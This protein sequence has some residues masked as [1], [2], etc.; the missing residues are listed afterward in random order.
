MKERTRAIDR[1]M[2][3]EERNNSV[4]WLNVL[5]GSY[6]ISVNPYNYGV[7]ENTFRKQANDEGF[8]TELWVDKL[9]LHKSNY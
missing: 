9:R 2:M 6:Y 7:N 8:A 5:C 1:F 4:R 3:D